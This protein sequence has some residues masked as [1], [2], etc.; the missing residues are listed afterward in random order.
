MNALYNSIDEKCLSNLQ[1][2][3][4]STNSL[5][6]YAGAVAEIRDTIRQQ[7]QEKIKKIYEIARLGLY[8][9]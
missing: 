1:E 2:K 3:I 4:I 6:S 5:F 7:S 8:S 9:D